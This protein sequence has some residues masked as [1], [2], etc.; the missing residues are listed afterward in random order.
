[1]ECIAEHLAQSWAHRGIIS[2]AEIE[3]CTYSLTKRFSTALT[4]VIMLIIGILIS[5]ICNVV[6][7]MF[8]LSFLRKSTN[9]YHAHTY[10]QCACISA[11]LEVFSLLLVSLINSICAF[12]LVVIA[13]FVIWSLA[14]ANNNRIH[15]TSRE[16]DALRISSRIR[17][18]ILIILF[19]VLIFTFPSLAN[20]V[21]LSLTADAILLA[22]A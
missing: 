5:N 4:G 1:V 11:T 7:F 20:C 15:L 13:W 12:C 21:A 16:L 14:P 19:F 3:W 8:C 9:G 17:L 10:W 18:H 22:F 2:D 6:L